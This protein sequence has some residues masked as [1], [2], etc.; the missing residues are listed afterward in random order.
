MAEEIPRILGFQER[1]AKRGTPISFELVS[2]DTD[3]A[4]IDAFREK[5]AGIPSSLRLTDASRLQPWL[6][7]LGLDPGAGLPIHVF[8]DSKDK[9][10]SAARFDEVRRLLGTPT[11]PVREAASTL[12]R[13][14]A[15][16]VDAAREANAGM[17][18]MGAYGRSR[19]H[20]YFLGSNSAAVVRTSPVAVLLA[21]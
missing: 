2:V 8:V 21:R 17:V 5:H 16:I 4:L 3:T 20:E 15:K 1:L 11:V 12:G 19:I 14:D 7:S 18:V 9:G 6:T 10:R 13:P